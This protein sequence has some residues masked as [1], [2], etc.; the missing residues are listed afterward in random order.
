MTSLLRLGTLTLFLLLLWQSIISLFAIPNYILPTPEQVLITLYQQHH[1][2]FLQAIPTIIETLLGF[3]LGIFLGC[4]AALLI[5]FFRP[6]N[7]WFLPLLIISQA[8]PMFAIAPLLV[9]WLGYGLAAKIVTATLMIFF[10]IASAFYDGLQ[11]QSAGWRELA[12]TMNADKKRL[13]FRIHIPAA[14][15]HLGA[16]LRIAA[17]SAPIGAIISEWVG[18]SQGLGYLMMN[19]NG[20]MQIDLMFAAL[21]VIVII[22]LGLYFSVD[23]L[24]NRL[25]WW[26]QE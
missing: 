13:F 8:I 15:P 21:F 4:S 16:G 5:T 14:L 12:Q 17:V 3:A 1:L 26:H 20:R 25:I 23:K 9:I 6:L 24:L 2:I 22:A 7:F 10:P 11:R 19:A 18:A